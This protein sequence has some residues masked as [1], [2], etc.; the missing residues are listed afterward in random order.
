MGE[1]FSYHCKQFNIKWSASTNLFR[2]ND[3]SSGADREI[4]NILSDGFEALALR[5]SEMLDKG[6]PSINYPHDFNYSLNNV[7]TFISDWLLDIQW[8][9]IGLRL[10]SECCWCK[11]I[12]VIRSYRTC[13]LIKFLCS[14]SNQKQ[15]THFN[16]HTEW[17]IL[18]TS[19]QRNVKF[20]PCCAEP[21]VDISIFI[22]SYYVYDTCIAK[23]MFDW[24]NSFALIFPQ[25]ST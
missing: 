21:Y 20:Y 25:R 17:R 12:N 6:K 4:R 8:L 19:V 10:R 14:H 13:H 15:V 3:I 2:L 16:N 22:L 23:A 11:A 5:R 7:N 1:L 18:G 24:N 9:W